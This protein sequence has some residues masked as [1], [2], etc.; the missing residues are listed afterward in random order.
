MSLTSSTYFLFLLVL[1]SVYYLVGKR[2][3][4]YVLFAASIFFYLQAI[5]ADKTKVLLVLAYVVGITYLGALLIERLQGKTKTCVTVLAVG[6][7]IAGLFVLKYAYN[8]VSM[9]AAIFKGTYDFSWLQFAAVMGISYFTLSAIG[10]LI[11]VYWGIYS[12]ERNIV[13]VGLFVLYFP[14]VVSGPV[15]RFK[16]MK[17]QFMGQRP[18]YDTIVNGARRMAWGYFKKL[19][20]SERFAIVIPHIFEN[21]QQYSGIQILFAT[22][23]Y[24]LRLY[25][26]FSG[27]MDI[28]MGSSELFGIRLPENFRAPFLSRTVQE[29]WQRWHMTL[30]GWFKDYVMYPVQMFG[31]LVSLG[32][33]C[34]KRFGKNVGKKI[35]TYLAMFVLWLL[36]GVW[37]GG[38]AQYFVASA[39][40]PFVYLIVGDLLQPLWH[41]LD[42]K[43]AIN[44]GSFSFRCMQCVRTTLLLCVCWVFVCT[45]TVKAGWE[46][47]S[48]MVTK[49]LVPGTTALTQQL[50]G[51]DVRDVELMIGGILLLGAEHYCIEKD[52]SLFAA[53]DRQN[54]WFKYVLIYAEVLL[55]YV[56]GMVGS[57]SFIY[58]NF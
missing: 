21:Y 38:T 12:A 39:L 19:V 45:P 43:Y 48:H 18:D 32:K 33:K 51:L 8:M 40:V 53:V 42:A 13:T 3:Q 37:H 34:K 9:F 28:I 17:E 7:L 30:G 49:F 44:R 41:K 57:S 5:A 35:P 10:Y 31:P 27:C 6:G 36:I 15:V 4:K 11:D 2:L 47:L 22:L 24:V 50:R 20:L 29:F 26:D 55:I 23:C 46:V 1:V 54:K 52:G 58:F 14:L 16:Q 25:T 56:Y